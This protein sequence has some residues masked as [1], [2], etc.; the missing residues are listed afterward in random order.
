M[1]PVASTLIADPPV[2]V[3]SLLSKLRWPVTSDA[4]GLAAWG[5]IASA[6]NGHRRVNAWVKWNGSTLEAEVTE[7]V[8]DQ[9][10]QVLN[11]LWS[12]TETEGATFVGARDGAGVL[13]ETHALR[14]FAEA[15]LPLRSPSF[16]AQ[17][18]PLR[19]RAFG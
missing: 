7:S 4:F 12:V 1:N 14:R 15:I 18:V 10:S 11:L 16:M 5:N 2:P 6:S 17:P 13:E 19:R 9:P 3:A 8:R